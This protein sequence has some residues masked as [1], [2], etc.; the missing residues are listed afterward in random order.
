[1]MCLKCDAVTEVI[2][3][4]ITSNKRSVKRRRSCLSCGHRFTTYETVLND[5]ETKVL[6]V[7][8]KFVKGLT[9]DK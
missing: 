3:S 7:L 6:K 1:M 9:V 5:N 8:M 2:N 4:R